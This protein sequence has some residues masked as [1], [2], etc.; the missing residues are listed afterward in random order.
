MA[1]PAIKVVTDC[2]TFT[3]KTARKYSHIVVSRRSDK[4]IAEVRKY[5]SEFVDS[6]QRNPSEYP[7][8]Y[9]ERRSKEKQQFEQSIDQYFVNGFCGRLDLALSLAGTVQKFGY[10]QDIRVYTIAGERVL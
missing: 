3:R 10:H 8:G 9:F 6:Y 5:F 7:Q 2:G 1:K 4:R